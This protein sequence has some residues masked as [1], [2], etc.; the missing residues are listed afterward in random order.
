MGSRILTFL[1]ATFGFSMATDAS[2]VT[3][4]SG[5]EGWT[6]PTSGLGGPGTTLETT[7][8]NPGSNAHIRFHD[9]GIVFSN[10]SNTAFIGDL[11]TRGPLEF[12]SDVEVTDISSIGNPEARDL[13]VEFRSHVLAQGGFPY[14]SVFV[15][16]GTMHSGDPWTLYTAAFDPASATLPAGWGG[17]GAEDPLT[18]ESILPPGVTF[19]DVMGSV[20]EV[21]LSTLVPGFF[22]ID[23]DFDIRFDNIGLAGP[24]AAVH[25]APVGSA[26]MAL[27]ALLM[28][29]VSLAMLR[30]RIR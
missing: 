16:L 21:A 15:T 6:G 18:F 14:T 8:G 7:G 19:A 12:R 26:A 13:I 22:F 4:D 30:R 5:F 1:V 20:D 29:V 2:V 3:F 27:L 28:S 9:F 17:Y 24:S 11:S 23:D 25:A 10:N